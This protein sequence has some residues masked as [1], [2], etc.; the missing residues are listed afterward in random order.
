M[1]TQNNTKQLK[2]ILQTTTNSA[3]DG[4][5]AGLKGILDGAFTIVGTGIDAIP[6]TLN[7]ANVAIQEVGMNTLTQVR[8]LAFDIV[9]GTVK[10][11]YGTGKEIV[12]DLGTGAN[13]VRKEIAALI[14]KLP[15]V[16]QAADGQPVSKENQL[17]ALAGMQSDLDKLS[18][19][20]AE[21]DQKVNE[22]TK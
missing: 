19:I 16:A 12:T 1:E 18:S 2:V 3:I 17:K 22:A 14:A 9:G 4:L 21:I 11:T 10:F 15:K 20:Q 8:R 7:V 5:S 6:N 13:I